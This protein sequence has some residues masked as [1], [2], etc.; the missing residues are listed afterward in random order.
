MRFSEDLTARARIRDAAVRRFG[1]DGFA[2]T[3][4]KRIA[5]DA[6]VSAGLVVHHFGSK[7]GLIE[8]CDAYAIAF[9]EV[10]EQRTEGNH[11]VLA[12]LARAMVERSADTAPL[13]DQMVARSEQALAESEA[14]DTTDPKQRA[15]VLVA[16]EL[17]G[18][19]LR[20]H[21]GRY[22]GE[23][24]FEHIGRAMSEILTKGLYS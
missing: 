15:A 11:E 13:F 8:A 16:M 20:A 19:A 17:G 1:L 7:Q 21:L 6:R 5:A 9:A 12:Y 18:Y 24:D 22:F 23:A 14:R 4:I 2:G 10:A 3:P